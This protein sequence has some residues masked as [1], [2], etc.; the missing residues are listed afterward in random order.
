MED[1][2]M[3]PW[4]I[5][6]LIAALALATEQGRG[7]LKAAFREGIRAGYHVKESTLELADKAKDYKEELIAEIRADEDEESD[8]AKKKK[9][10]KAAT[11]A[12]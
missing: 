9:K 6:A 12:S 3:G 5:A 4:G 8:T 10:G 7:I 11:P 1:Y 2:N